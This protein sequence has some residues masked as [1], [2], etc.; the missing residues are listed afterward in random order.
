M[1]GGENMESSE[2]N[3]NE[4]EENRLSGLEELDRTGD[5]APLLAKESEK[6]TRGPFVA[7]PSDVHGLQEQEKEETKYSNMFEKRSIHT[8]RPALY[9]SIVLSI[10]AVGLAIFSL[11]SLY[12]MSVLGTYL[13]P[14][15][16]TA[17]ILLF[18]VSAMLAV[19]SVYTGIAKAREIRAHKY[20]KDKE[21]SETAHD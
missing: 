14:A 20:V 15:S 1:L 7:L 6:I 19:I 5:K 3:E 13:F 18:I 8:D 12:E 9:T 16:P 2:P 10:F 21:Q 4:N 11:A 17:F